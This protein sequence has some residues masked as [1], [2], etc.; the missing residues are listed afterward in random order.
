MLVA[1]VIVTFRK[2]PIPGLM[3]YVSK[4]QHAA[5]HRT[6]GGHAG[7]L[8][9]D[10]VKLGVEPREVGVIGAVGNDEKGE[11]AAECHV[12]GGHPPPVVHERDEQGGNHC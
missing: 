5:V 11:G 4:E 7:I 1:D 9:V 2:M 8:A 12:E 3:N 10:L 6:L